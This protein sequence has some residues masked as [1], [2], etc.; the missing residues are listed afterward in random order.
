[1]IILSRFRQT[2]LFIGAYA[3][4][5]I[6][7]A[8]EYRISFWVQVFTMVANDSLWLFFW[9]TYFQQFPVVHGWQ[10]SDIV[11]IWAVA[12]CAFGISAGFFG[13]ASK[14]ATLIMNG[15]LD[16]YLGMPR[17]VLLHVCISA[18]DPTAWG[19]IIFAVGSFVL[20]LHPGLLQ[21]GLFVVL[22][23]MSAFIF[24]SFLVIL[25]SLAFFLGTTAG[26]AQ[27]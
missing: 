16:A 19:D 12:A 15:G 10:N 17:N 4:A 22:A 1:M 18:S 20:L 5:N 25:G 6:Q 13:N 27:Q 23:P 26:L 3:S 7:A 14:L 11:V 2:L 8:M 24:A 21:I 9:W